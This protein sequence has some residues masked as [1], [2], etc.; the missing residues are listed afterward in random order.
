MEP[1]SLRR[2][3]SILLEI[4]VGD[5]VGQ[6]LRRGVGVSILLEILVVMGCEAYTFAFKE[7]AFQSFLRF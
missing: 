1:A 4:L 3:V 7:E 6:Q 5:V 2:L